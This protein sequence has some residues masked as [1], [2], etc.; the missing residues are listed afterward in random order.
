MD[1]WGFL[2][3]VYAQVNKVIDWFSNEYWTLRDGAAHALDWAWNYANW[4]LNTAKTWALGELAKLRSLAEDLYEAG[5]NFTQSL[6]KW[7]YNEVNRLIG[8]AD[9]A[10]HEAKAYLIGLVSA[11]YANAV[12]LA[13]TL[14]D[15]AKA[16]ARL[17]VDAAKSEAKSL[18]SPLLVLKPVLSFLT[19]LGSPA[20]SSK[21]LTLIGSLYETLALLCNDPIKFIL[22]L[23]WPKMTS[24]LCYLIAYGLG[25]VHDDL[26][27]IPQWK[28]D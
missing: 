3:W 1:F 20:Q 9:A 4:A 19:S 22:N 11:A 8:L 14:Y 17:L 23:L 10:L 18:Y 26:P 16:F 24:Y 5:S 2:N 7:L 25:T 12:N 27:P 6:F 21:L 13:N 28:K 15:N